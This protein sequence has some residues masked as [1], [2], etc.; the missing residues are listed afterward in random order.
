[1]SE[2][3]P[4]EI[5]KVEV[6]EAYKRVKANR[7]AAGVD[8]QSLEEFEANL[9][10]NLY[11][12]WNRMSSGSYMPPPVRRVEIPKKGGGIRPLGV[13]IPS[14]NYPN[15]KDS[16]RIGNHHLTG[17]PSE[18]RAIASDPHAPKPGWTAVRGRRAPAWLGAPAPGGVDRPSVR[19]G[20]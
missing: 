13:P 1:M 20:A 12:I 8:M 19:L 17:P 6:W 11:K 7:G 18:G 10:G 5:G 14:A 15:L 9:R 16:F 2:A 4:Y 3:K